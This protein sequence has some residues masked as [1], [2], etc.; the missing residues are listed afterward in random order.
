MKEMILE[1]YTAGLDFKMDSPMTAAQ[2]GSMISELVGTIARHCSEAG[3]C[4]IGHIKG[5]A[6]IP[7]NG[8]LKISVIS[9]NHP[10]DV[11]AESGDD[12]SELS[13]TLNV[14]VYGH[15]KKM[16]AQLTR[17]TVDLPERPWSGHVKMKS[18][19]RG[20][21]QISESSHS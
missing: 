9:S 15:T 8:F 14:I 19:E 20:H 3:P 16:L 2:W 13:M 10:A 11:D 17:N 21:I 18:V 12:S 1:P 5:L 6:I 7:G 4:V